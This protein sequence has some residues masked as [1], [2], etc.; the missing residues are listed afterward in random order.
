MCRAQAP[1]GNWR[2][3]LHS[4]LPPTMRESGAACRYGRSVAFT[5]R[6]VSNGRRIVFEEQRD[7][8][9]ERWL[10]VATHVDGGFTPEEIERIYADALSKWMHPAGTPL[11]SAD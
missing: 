9:T 5:F 6:Y 3:G 4:Q 11:D 8:R 10:L 1:P 7:R 2:E